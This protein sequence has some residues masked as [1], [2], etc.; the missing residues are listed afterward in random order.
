MKRYTLRADPRREG[1]QFRIAYADEL[2]PQQL[3]AATTLDG[4]V[5][6]VAGAGSGKTRTLVY[7]VA[8]LV[9]SGVPA[10]AILLLTFTRKAAEEMLRRASAL[11]GGNCAQ[12]A[13]GTFHSFAHLT[14]RRYGRIVGLDSGFT[15]LD[16]SDS[17]DVVNLLRAEMGLDRKEMVNLINRGRGHPQMPTVFND[18]FIPEEVAQLQPYNLEEARREIIDSRA[19]IE[20]STDLP[21][22]MFC[23]PKGRFSRRHLE[24]IRQAGYRRK[25][26]GSYVRRALPAVEFT[27]SQTKLNSEVL[28]LDP[29][30]FE[31]LP[32]GI[33]GARYQW[34]DLDGEGA[35]GVVTDFGGQW[36][37]KRNLSPINQVQLG[38]K[39][40]VTR[41]HFGPLESVG[42]LPSQSGLSHARVLDL[43]GAG[44]LAIASFEPAA[45]GFFERTADLDWE[46]FQTFGSVATVDWSDPNVRLVDL[47]GDGR[48]D[49]LITDTAAFTIYPSLGRAGFGDGE[50]VAT[51][52]DEERGPEVVL[53]DGTETIYLA[54]M[55]GDGLSDLVRVRGHEICYWPNLGYG[56]FGTKVTMDTPP[57]LGDANAFDPHRVRLADIDGSGTTDL[58]YVGDDGVRVCFNQS[59]NGFAPPQ[60]LAIFPGLSGVVLTAHGGG[61]C[62]PPV[63]RPHGGGQTALDDRHAQQSRGR[64]PNALCALDAIL[65]GG[66][67]CRPSLDHASA[68]SGARD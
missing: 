18:Y 43:G 53:A 40:Q 58:L 13:G 20:D 45:A 19:W 54:D 26:D 33:D 55:S 56:R 25:A 21:C 41:A 32:E 30:D 68:L 48:A 10:G 7:R 57:W 22:P 38:D 23:P 14:L 11:V 24:L 6:V 27:Y 3:E 44:R 47:T 35:S 2:N 59:G 66:R 15:I 8:R 65:F 67:P 62:S 61:G 50:F 39:S 4:P 29:L 1:T 42:S 63:R 37:Y 17:E 12:V 16:R 5:L 64:D 9:E 34:V 46:P 51:P 52:W 60:P 49:I 28:T 31:N 36:G